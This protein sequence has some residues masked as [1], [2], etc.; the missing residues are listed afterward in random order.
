MKCTSVINFIIET[1]FEELKE[2]HEQFDEVNEKNDY[3]VNSFNVFADILYTSLALCNYQI[4]LD[5]D[6]ATELFNDLCLMMDGSYEIPPQIKKF[7]YVLHNND[8]I[9]FMKHLK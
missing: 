4:T 1:T 7:Y 9:M 3:C 6:F 8:S 2:L 5:V